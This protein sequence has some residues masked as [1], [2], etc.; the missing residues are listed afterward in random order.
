MSYLSFPICLLGNNVRP[1]TIKTPVT[2]DCIA[3]TLARF[4][5]IRAPNACSAAPLSAVR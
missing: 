3:P 5:R 1:E 4:M 2:V